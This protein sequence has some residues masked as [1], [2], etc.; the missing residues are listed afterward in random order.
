M[1]NAILN[2]S[3]LVPFVQ[4]A[5]ETFSIMLDCQ[6]APGC[7]FYCGDGRSPLD[8]NG[9]IALSG[10]LTGVVVLGVDREVGLAAATQLLGQAP[11]EVGDIVVDIVREVTNQVAGQAKAQLHYGLLDLQLPHVVLGRGERLPNVARETLAWLPF[12]SKWGAICLGVG[13][14]GKDVGKSAEGTQG[15][16]N[17]HASH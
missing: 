7:A 11:S 13:L 8:V 16:V 9:V 2:D 17:E 6:I 3:L 15:A 14:S 5:I 12:E 1:E 4:A 10:P